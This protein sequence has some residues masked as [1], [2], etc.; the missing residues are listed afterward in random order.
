[1]ANLHVL[2]STRVAR[3]VQ[4][5]MRE[6]LTLSSLDIYTFGM[7]IKCVTCDTQQVPRVPP[8][9]TANEY[10][11]SAMW[12]CVH[13]PYASNAGKLDPL[14]SQSVIPETLFVT[15]CIESHLSDVC[16][17]RSGLCVWGQTDADSDPVIGRVMSLLGPCA[18]AFKSF[19]PLSCAN[20]ATYST[21]QVLGSS[22][23]L[24]RWSGC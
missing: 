6:V 15:T 11:G 12:L 2:Q 8:G 7:L 22:R 13:M 21:V 4:W 10:L 16:L 1:M 14:I 20:R 19:V 23:K 3:K 17:S 5:H 24:F 9:L 18:T